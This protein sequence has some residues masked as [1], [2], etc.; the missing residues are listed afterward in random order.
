[1]FS[2]VLVYEALLRRSSKTYNQLS[3][4]SNKRL[5]INQPRK[6]V[7]AKLVLA[8]IEDGAYTSSLSLALSGIL[9]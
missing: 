5:S 8:W 9:S 1:M 6:F 4:Q 3:S 2:A 7:S